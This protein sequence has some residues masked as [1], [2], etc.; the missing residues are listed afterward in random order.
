MASGFRSFIV[1]LLVS[2][3]FIIALISFNVGLITDNGGNSTLLDSEQIN[4]AYI[5]INNSLRD[6]ETEFSTQ[7][8]IVAET[9]PT[10]A[11]NIILDTLAGTWTV[12]ISIPQIIYTSIFGL[13]AEVLTG[14]DSDFNVF[15][16]TVSAILILIGTLAAW[17]M[18][19]SGE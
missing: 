14:G 9:E 15:W 4:A 3:L 13:T 12:F 10:S 19:R 6:S 5:T 17:R 18:L 11:F 7:S 1:S 16:T 2:G 8:N